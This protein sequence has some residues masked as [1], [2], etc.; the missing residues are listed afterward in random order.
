MRTAIVVGW[1]LAFLAAGC[2]REAA[3]PKPEP[4]GWHGEL[5]PP[6]GTANDNGRAQHAVPLR[7]ST[8]KRA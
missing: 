4:A 1:A 5:V 7:Q 6:W 3:P 2:R 8:A